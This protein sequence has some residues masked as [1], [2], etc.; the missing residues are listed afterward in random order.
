MNI[1]V[2]QTRLSQELEHLA[3][4]SEVSAPAVTRII[5]SLQDM[6]ARSYLDTLFQDAGLVIRKDALGNTFARWQGSE[7][8]LPA[9][10]TGSHIDAIPN[11]G[12]Y[13]GTVGVLGALEAVRALQV[14]GFKPKRSIELILFTAEEPTRFGVGCLGSRVMSGTL[15]PETLQTLKDKDGIHPDM[16]RL[17]AGFIGNL[18]EVQLSQGHY[19]AFVELHI[20]QGALL[21]R[22]KLDI[23]VV[24]AV[25][26]P[27]TLH[28]TLEGYGGHAGALLMPDRKDALAAASEIVL[29]VERA[30]KI[31]GS[32]DSVATVGILDIHP[33]AVNSVPSKVF[34]TVDARDIDLARRDKMIQQIKAAVHIAREERGVIGK[35]ETI[36]ADP[37]ATC[38][39]EIIE[40]IEASTQGLNLKSLS[41]VSRAYHDTLFMARICP[42]SMIFIPC[43]DGVSHRPDEYS[44]PQDIENGVKVLAHTLMKLSS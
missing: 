19:S 34:M 14:S 11:A 13:D 15:T 3:T 23:G 26:A 35:I 32:L 22:Q 17:K 41:M 27:A 4:F 39:V 24:T 6:Q 12:M 42:V 36:N 20:E 18:S 8:E 7:A 28:I 38:A 1:Q 5:Y 10:A 25:A 21:E 44:K 29:A 2:N 30:A 9:I 33:R 16:A 40:A 31:S 43:K 37:P